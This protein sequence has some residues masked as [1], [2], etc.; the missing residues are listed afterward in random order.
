MDIQFRVCEV[1]FCWKEI[2]SISSVDDESDSPLEEDSLSAV[3]ADAIPRSIAS[4]RLKAATLPISLNLY[5]NKDKN[6]FRK[7]K[8]THKPIN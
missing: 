4:I 2:E 1:D 5:D 7:S 8:N 3:D 6:R